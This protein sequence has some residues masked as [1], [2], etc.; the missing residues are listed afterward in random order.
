MLSIL[1]YH[2]GLR[3]RKIFRKTGKNKS[4]LQILQIFN[5]NKVPNYGLFIKVFSKGEYSM[6]D[7]SSVDI[8]SVA[9]LMQ[10]ALWSTPDRIISKKA[11]RKINYESKGKL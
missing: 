10:A 2:L 6:S 3:E 1:Y 5:Y 7:L 11:W 9:T 8:H 4:S